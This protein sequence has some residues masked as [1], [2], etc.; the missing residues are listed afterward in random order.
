MN[1]IRTC[2]LLMLLTVMTAGLTAVPAIARP[3]M[4][5]L[6]KNIA[7]TGSA[8]YRFQSKKFVSQDGER[9]YRVWLAIPKSDAP[10]GGY[11]VLW[12]LDG[13]AAMAHLTEPLLKKLSS[14]K[15]PVLVAVGYD[16]HLPFDV[17]AR[18]YDYT[19]PNDAPDTLVT[20]PHGRKGGGSHQFRQLLLNTIVPWAE[21]LAPSNPQRRALWGHSYGGL[22]V[23]D[24]FFHAA[25]FS[26]YFSAAPSL[27]WNHQ[28]ILT[29]ARRADAGPLKHL[30]LYLMEGDGI[31]ERRT[32]H[33]DA[34]QQEERA[35]TDILRPSGARLILTRYPGQSH[36]QILPSSLV[37]TLEIV[38]GSR[39]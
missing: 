22:F 2:F 7:D 14:G 36:G 26:H 15:P 16:T 35:L 11:P 37:D 38:S 5:P 13:N 12:L 8:W 21:R 29:L 24:T 3:D 32:G 19:P 39:D 31:T 6:G 28:R 1:T 4:R 17:V 10:P 18:N 33:S 9:H 20:Q 23:L 34:L 25:W 27:S 30:S